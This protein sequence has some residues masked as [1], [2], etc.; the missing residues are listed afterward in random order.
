MNNPVSASNFLS[1][2]KESPFAT[3][4][5]LM[6]KSKNSVPDPDP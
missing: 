2:N 3:L 6:K 5:L 1:T 4:F